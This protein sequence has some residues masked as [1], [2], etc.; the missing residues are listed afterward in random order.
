MPVTRDAILDTLARLALPAGVDR[1]LAVASG[2][3]GWANP[4]YRRTSPWRC[5][6]R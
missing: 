5:S 2:K 4:P 3:G 1:R 6:T